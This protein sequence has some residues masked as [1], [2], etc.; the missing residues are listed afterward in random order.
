MP[1][2]LMLVACGSGS[3]PLS[4]TAT[5]SGTVVAAPC[6][7]VERQGD[8]PCPPVAG[9][10]VEFGSATAVTDASGSYH[11]ALMPGTYAIK[12]KAGSW[13]RPANPSSTTVPAGA[14]V[15]NLTYDSGIR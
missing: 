4:P 13:E 3:S 10:T 11:L 5:V 6:R 9:V 14:T 7:P 2:V 8:P 12:V 15:L 1:L